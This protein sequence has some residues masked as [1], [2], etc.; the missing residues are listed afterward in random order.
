M[1]KY[2][3]CSIVVSEGVKNQDGAF[4]SESGLVD[5]FGHKQ[6]GGVAPVIAKIIKEKLGYKY[7]WALADYL[8]RSARH[9]ASQT[10][11][12]Q[13]YAVGQAAVLMALAGKNAVMPIIVREKGAQ[14]QWT[15][16]EAPLEKVANVEKKMP[17]DYITDDGFG[18]TAACRAYLQPLIQGESYPPYHNGLPAYVKLKNKP[19]EKKLKTT[20]ELA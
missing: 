20:F 14:Y 4:I 6:L 1:K 16:G 7:H 5:A 11:V 19:V 3:H 12:D 18:I 15:I 2:D 9:I 17:R 13:A 10:D 8:Q